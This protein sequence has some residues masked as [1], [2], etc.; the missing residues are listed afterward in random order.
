M[1]Y[2]TLVKEF[3]DYW[4]SYEPF[5][6]ETLSTSARYD[7]L[8][9]EIV[10][11]R[12]SVMAITAEIESINDANLADEEQAAAARLQEFREYLGA[13][14][15]ASLTLG[16]LVAVA[17]VI[18][19]RFLERG[20]ATEQERARQAEQEMRRLSNQLVRTQEEERK[21]LSRELHDELGQMLTA[22]GMEIGRLE[23]AHQVGSPTFSSTVSEGKALIDRM[24]RLVRDLAMGLRPSMLDDLGLEP[25]LAWRSSGPGLDRHQG[26]DQGNGRH[27]LH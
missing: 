7:L 6:D 10:P 4:Q 11:R 16:L 21:S 23:R 22:L 18:R 17:A 27:G 1:R 25:A 5:F 15:R 24:M 26:A 14:L 12:D 20:S 13:M 19:I 3:N 9:R 2:E 8:R